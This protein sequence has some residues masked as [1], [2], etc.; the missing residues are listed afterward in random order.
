[1]RVKLNLFLLVINAI[2]TIAAYNRNDTSTMMLGI[3]VMMLCAIG[4][5]SAHLR[6]HLKEQI[7]ERQRE[8]SRI[9]PE[10]L[11]PR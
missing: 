8:R 1:M 10:D 5:Y 2:I 6:D 9:H 4:A 11:Y 3:V 7:L